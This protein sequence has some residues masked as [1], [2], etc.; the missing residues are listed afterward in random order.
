ML[1]LLELGLYGFSVS[2]WKD[3]LFSPS[4]WI[5]CV[6]ICWDKYCFWEVIWG[7]RAFLQHLWKYRSLKLLWGWRQCLSS[8]GF[9]ILVV[10]DGSKLHV[11]RTVLNQRLKSNAG[12]PINSRLQSIV[13]FSSEIFNWL[14]ACPVSVPGVNL[15]LTR[16]KLGPDLVL[17]RS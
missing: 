13:A 15:V 8:L 9:S 7:D 17:D 11:K 2:V 3:V 10:E 1:R 6:L 12:P 5:V 4:M 14:E 16:V